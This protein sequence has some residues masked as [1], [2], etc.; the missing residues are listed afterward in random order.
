MNK[1]VL[2]ERAGVYARLMRIDRPIGAL[3]L[4]WPTMWALWIASEGH[5]DG[6]IVTVFLLGVF[7]MR[8]AGC[9]INDY[10]DRRIDRHVSRTAARP[11]ATGEASPREALTLFATLAVLAFGLVLL[12]NPLTISLSVIAVVLAASYPF[13]KR[14]TYLPQVHLGLAFGWAVPMSFA[15]QTAGVPVVAWL[16]LLAVVLWAVVYDTMYAMADR[17]DDIKIGVKSTAI[18]FGESDRFWIGLFQI[19]LVSVLLIIGYQ[20]ALG[21]WYYL[22]IGA[23]VLLSV[24]QQYLIRHRDPGECFKAFLNNNW[25]GGAVFAGIAVNFLVS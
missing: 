24:Y 9:V 2:I 11:L 1:D 7:L 5:P 19:L 8:A 4:L 23:A 15:A 13:M 17:D 16:L 3:L 18:L 12:M 21:P 10:A 25:L 6:L 22:G 20:T 14:Y